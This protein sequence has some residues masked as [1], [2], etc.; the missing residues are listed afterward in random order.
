VRRVPL[1][2]IVGDEFDEDSGGIIDGRFDFA[3]AGDSVE[4]MAAALDGEG[5]VAM[6]GGKVSH[7]LIELIGLDIFESLGVLVGEDKPLDVRCGVLKTTAKNGTLEV[8]TLVFDTEDTMIVGDGEIDLEA[9]KAN[10]VLTPQPKDFSPFTVRSPI[11][12]AGPLREVDYY[13]DAAG[14]G[15]GGKVKQV[16][17]TALSAVLG[18]LPPFDTVLDENSPCRDLLE[19]ARK[20]VTE[21]SGEEAQR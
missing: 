1:A 2:E 11:R 4:Q 17:S 7:L 10:V 18:L 16:L 3:S 20:S 6:S 5:F 9:E 13:P 21:A 14:L 8:D 12:I 15:P 19:D